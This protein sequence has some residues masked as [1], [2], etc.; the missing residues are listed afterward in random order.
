MA[1]IMNGVPSQVP[2]Q[3]QE[4]SGY[5]CEW[6]EWP[7]TDACPPPFFAAASQ[8]RLQLWP[9]VHLRE[10]R[11]LPHGQTF[12]DEPRSERIRGLLLPES[13]I[14]AACLSTEYL[15]KRPA[16]SSSSSSLSSTPHH[17]YCHDIA[18]KAVDT[19]LLRK[20]PNLQLHL[21]H[22]RHDRTSSALLP[23]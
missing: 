22:S 9:S 21:S 7:S 3:S 12:H 18:T 20:N 2:N 19:P 6:V 17:T 8:G 10:D 16:I 5:C 14:C 11:P 13:R 1:P 4:K 15:L 23:I